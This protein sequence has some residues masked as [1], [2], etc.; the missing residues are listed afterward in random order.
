MRKGKRLLKCAE[1]LRSGPG[2]APGRAA[3]GLYPPRVPRSDPEPS[4]LALVAA[5]VVAA[6]LVAGCGYYSFTGATIPDHLRT[7]S[8]PLADDRAASPIATLD[9]QLTQLLIERFVGQTR[10]AL[11]SS[12]PEADAVL[13]ASIDRYT[14]TPTAVSGQ[15]TASLSRVTISVS[16]EYMDQREQRELLRRSFSGFEDFDPVGE[17]L[18][19]EL[20]AAATALRNIADDVFTAATS[21]W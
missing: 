4:I 10:L 3:E 19:G 1:H 21:N 20:T 17:G 11:E 16:V 14:N 12:E 2:I 9:E 5:T 7:I 13:T 8:I 6:A 15:E 18:E